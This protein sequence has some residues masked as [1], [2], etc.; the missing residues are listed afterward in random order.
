MIAL[1]CR[2]CGSTAIRKNGK[3]NAGRQQIHCT[4]CNFHSTADLK[5]SERSYRER[6][7]GKLH[8]ERI[9]QHGISRTSHMSG[10]TVRCILKKKSLIPIAGTFSPLKERPIPEMDE[11]WSYVGKKKNPVWIWLAMERA[12]RRIVGIA[13]GDRSWKTCR[14]LWQSLPPDYRKRAVCH[15][16]YWESHSLVLPSKRHRPVG[17]ESGETAHIGRFNNT[18]RQ[19][20][21]DMVRKTLSFSRSEIF[22]KL[23]IR[24]FIDYYNSGLSV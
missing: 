13:F 20:C 10:T 23:R 4:S 7:V 3:N 21:A 22:H 14:E 6:M 18:L 24:S 11:I 12:T 2:R 5:S 16:D 8:C 17:K 19:R 15:T 9:S 1:K